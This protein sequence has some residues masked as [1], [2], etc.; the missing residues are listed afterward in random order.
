[1]FIIVIKICVCICNQG[2]FLR[3][4][5]KKYSKEYI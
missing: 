4:K 1:M 2:E 3:E 5:E